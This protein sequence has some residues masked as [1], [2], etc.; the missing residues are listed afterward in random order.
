MKIKW[1]TPAGSVYTLFQDAIKKPHIL[2]AGATGSG[3]SVLINGLISTMLYSCPGDAGL[4]LIDPKRVELA[5]YAKLPHTI[6]H[7]AGHNPQ[8][9]ATAF[10]RAVSIMDRRYTAM[11]KQRVKE[12]SGGHIYVIVDEWASIIKSDLR[13]RPCY[14]SVLRLL[15]EGRAARVHVILATQ[16]PKANII[17]T[18]I[19]ENF[20][21]R[22][23]LFTNTAQESRVL[24]DCNGCE[25]LPDPRTE[26]KALAYYVNPGKNNRKLV[27]IPYV[28]HKELD[29]ICAAWENQHRHFPKWLYQDI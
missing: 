14:K 6:A 16:V 19:R 20:N 21:T 25:L 29:R 9:W 13:G 10:Q 27:T 7:A 4:I 12:Y 3:K 18:E 15:S 5:Q 22:F 1:T 8:A 24:M 23:C 26:G 17:P 2:I 28:Q 11:E